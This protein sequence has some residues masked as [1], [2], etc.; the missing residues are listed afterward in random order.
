MLVEFFVPWNP[1]VDIRIIILSTTVQVI[2]LI[3]PIWPISTKDLDSVSHV[4]FIKYWKCLLNYL[5]LYHIVD[6]K[7][8][9]ISSTVHEIWLIDHIWQILSS[10]LDLQLI[11]ADWPYLTNF[12]NWPWL[13]RSS[14]LQAILKMFVR[15]LFLSNPMV[16]I[17]ITITSNTVH[18]IWLIDRI[19]PSDLDYQGHVIFRRN[20]KYI[21]SIPCSSKLY[22]RHQNNDYIVYGSRD[23]ADWPLFD[24]L[25][26]VT[27][28]SKV[29]WSSDN[30]ENMLARFLILSNP[31]W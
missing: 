13:P 28:N 1:M 7:I 21:C 12:V 5:I 11:V 18:K 29:T 14:D 6:I 9:I 19:C 26:Q 22:S 20:L 15:F 2:W 4:I 25:C 31:I 8:M 30:L 10:D 3:D 24:Q 23:M 27:W 17:I 16:D